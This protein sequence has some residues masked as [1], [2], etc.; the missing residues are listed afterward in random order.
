MALEMLGPRIDLVT[1]RML[2]DEAS[3]RAFATC[4]LVASRTA[5]AVRLSRSHSGDSSGRNDLVETRWNSED[6]RAERNFL[7][8]R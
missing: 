5:D 6:V 4:A 8:G 1:A 2:A 7:C 3:G